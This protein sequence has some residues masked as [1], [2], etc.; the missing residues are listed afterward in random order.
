MIQKRIAEKLLEASE[1]K[2]NRNRSV[3]RNSPS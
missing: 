2:I 3:K 1:N